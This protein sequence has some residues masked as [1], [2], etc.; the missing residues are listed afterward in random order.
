M[1]PSFEQLLGFAIRLRGSDGAEYRAVLATPRLVAACLAGVD[2]HK[3]QCLAW[4]RSLRRSAQA[5]IDTAI[6]RRQ[7]N[8]YLLANYPEMVKMR[9]R[10]A[11]NGQWSFSSSGC[12]GDVPATK[13]T[14]SP[15]SSN[16]TPTPY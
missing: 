8:P 4:E 12:C 1:C 5:T 9:S 6:N 11:P 14:L 3:P 7:P 13:S 15:R 16:Y 2:Q 10:A